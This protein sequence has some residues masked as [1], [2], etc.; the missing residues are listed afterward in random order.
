MKREEIHSFPSGIN[1]ILSKAIQTAA[2]YPPPGW[3]PSVYTFIGRLD[4][5]NPPKIANTPKTPIEETLSQQ[6]KDISVLTV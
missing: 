4:L 6:V 3:P 2:E 5:C 1:L